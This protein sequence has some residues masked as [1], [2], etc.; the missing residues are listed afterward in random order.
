VGKYVSR[1]THQGKEILI[2][3]IPNSNEEQRLEAWAEAKQVLLQQ[4]GACLALVDVRN[5]S[6]APGSMNKAKEAA[7]AARKDPGNRIAFVG[8]TR[9]QSSTAQI[10]LR[11]MRVRAHFCDTLDEGKAW[12]VREDDREDGKRK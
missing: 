11:T 7:A 8:L 12:L 9:L 2:L 5:I 6:L 1:T 3:S 10:A 4:K